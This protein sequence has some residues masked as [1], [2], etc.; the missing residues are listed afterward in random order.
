MKLPWPSEEP[1]ENEILAAGA[2]V[3]HKK[4]LAQLGVESIELRNLED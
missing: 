1:D 3:E 2:F 4:V